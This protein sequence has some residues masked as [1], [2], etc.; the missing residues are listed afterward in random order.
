MRPLRQPAE[1]KQLNN[2][3]TIKKIKG[4]G[5][6]TCLFL[7]SITTW[8]QSTHDW[9]PN[10]SLS[11]AY[12]LAFNLQVQ[13]ARALL[14]EVKTPE[15]I[16]VASLTDV[17]EL[18]V[19]E[20]DVKFEKYEDAYDQRLAV[21]EQ[22]KPATAAS[23]FAL[24]E[25]RLQWA[26]TYLKFGH[27]LDAAWNIRQAY[28]TVQECKKKYP[29]FIPI[30]KSSG[31]LEIMLGSV[32]EKYQWIIGL[33]NMQ[34]SIDKGLFE[35][36]LVRSKSPSLN[37][38]TTLVYYLFQG[39][40]LQQT[41]Q[42]LRGL[43][44]ELLSH[45]NNRLALF[46]GASL[47]IKNSNSERALALLK[48]VNTHTAGVPIVYAGYQQGEVY[49]HKGEY[50]SSIMMYTR[51]LDRYRGRNYVKD[52]HYKIGICYWLSG[53]SEEAK[54]AFERAK[55]EGKETT[56]A[57]KYAARSLAEATYP[58]VKLSKLRYATDGGYYEEA[59]AIISTITQHDLSSTKEKIEL[60]YRK[61]RLAHKIGSLQEAE[62][63][64]QETVT[65]Q[66]EELWYFAP[67]AC[68]QLGY[69]VLEKNKIEPARQYFEKA[70]SYKKHEYKNSIDSKAKS[71]LAQ[72]KKK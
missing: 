6:I 16:Y 70:L 22:L 3:T 55:I 15:Q 9:I 52:A 71:A 1:E 48:K 17:L 37:F 68:L 39:F 35:L 58:N 28:L 33:L 46:L 45:T 63:Y 44:T 25:L 56:E 24:A 67:N 38:E 54:K 34:G 50:D 7:C 64:Y 27:E 23:L 20:D 43:E 41:E 13:E 57:D 42:A 65:Q 72:L 31:M 59:H 66:G 26:F 2:R 18:L 14:T 19:T 51:F 30:Q 47:A 4:A 8:A 60:T 40:V 36:E 21:L 69:L 32:P 62:K 29:E 10:E 11:R 61:A 53:K 5:F 12:E 49:L